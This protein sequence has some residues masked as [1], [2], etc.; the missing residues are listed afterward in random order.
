M[1]ACLI[2]TSPLRND[3]SNPRMNESKTFVQILNC[4]R[5]CQPEFYSEAS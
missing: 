1:K 3:T 2:L 5:E 4:S